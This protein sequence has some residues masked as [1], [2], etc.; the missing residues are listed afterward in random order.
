[1]SKH[2]ETAQKFARPVQDA[3]APVNLKAQNWRNRAVELRAIA[4]RCKT[5]QERQKFLEVAGNWE[6]MAEA[7]LRFISPRRGT[8]I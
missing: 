2:D 1:M 8:M 4:A 7:E 6:K 5:A 3:R